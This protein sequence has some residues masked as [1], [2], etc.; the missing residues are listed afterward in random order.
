MAISP[1][2]CIG[3]PCHGE[4]ILAR[5]TSWAAYPLFP[6]QNYRG[7]VWG[8]HFRPF[9]DHGFGQNGSL[10]RVLCKISLWIGSGEA[11]FD[12]FS[13]IFVEN[14]F[15]ILFENGP[16]AW[17]VNE[18]PVLLKS[19]KNFLKICEKI[20]ILLNRKFLAKWSGR[21]GFD[22]FLTGPANFF[23]GPGH[24]ETSEFHFRDDTLY[25]N[26]HFLKNFFHGPENFRKLF[27]K[28]WKK[29]S[30]TLKLY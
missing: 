16:A 30:K 21:G 5:S 25:K 13:Q 3:K 9:S 7:L 27:G 11:V 19:T 10:R 23:H 24:S 1:T 14:L 17:K 18:S 6:G 8:G 15:F 4:P 12:H 22:H 2:H 29:C 20:K 28:I 26:D